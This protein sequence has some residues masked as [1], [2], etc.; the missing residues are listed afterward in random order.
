MYSNFVVDMMVLLF[1]AFLAST[2][3][4]K[5]ALP[6]QLYSIG[7]SHLPGSYLVYY[8]CWNF[9]LNVNI[10]PVISVSTTNV[11]KSKNR[12]L[13]ENVDH[14]HSSILRHGFNVNFFVIFIIKIK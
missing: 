1:L 12:K 5:A 3:V 4:Q 9:I 7:Q 2:V 10:V 8:E 14:F 6:I 13:S 11:Y